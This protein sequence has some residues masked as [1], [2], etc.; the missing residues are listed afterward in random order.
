MGRGRRGVYKAEK[1]WK[2]LKRQAKQDARRKFRLASESGDGVDV[3][4]G[5]HNHPGEENPVPDSADEVNRGETE[6]AGKD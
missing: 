1:R 6:A 5:S 2:E 3:S 4:E